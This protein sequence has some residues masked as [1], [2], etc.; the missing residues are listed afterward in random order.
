[1]GHLAWADAF[2][3]TADSVSLISEA[4]ST[5][6]DGEKL[7]PSL[8]MNILFSEVPKLSFI[9]L[10]SCRKPVYVMGGDRCKWK[11]LDFHK[12]LRERGMV[13]PFTGSEDVSKYSMACFDF[14]VA[15]R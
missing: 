5:G 13:R 10:I 15:S 7:Y 11:L 14:L 1:M 9:M 4:C 2:V 12:S 6:Y 8:L 3:I